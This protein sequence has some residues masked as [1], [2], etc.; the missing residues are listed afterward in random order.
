MKV[1]P[2]RLSSLLCVLVRKFM[3]KN[4]LSILSAS[5]DSNLTLRV[6]GLPKVCIAY[7]SR[8]THAC[9]LYQKRALTA[10]VW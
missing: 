8:E 10:M 7:F 9:Y 1:F 4:C 3:R 2:L 5:A 6:P